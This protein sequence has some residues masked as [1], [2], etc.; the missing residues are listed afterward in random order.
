MTT[1]SRLARHTL[2]PLAMATPTIKPVYDVLGIF[3]TVTAV[4]YICAPFMLLNIYDSLRAWHTLGYYGFV[5]IFGGLAFFYSPVGRAA[6]ARAA[7]VTAKDKEKSGVQERR[8]T[9][10]LKA[11]MPKADALVNG[12]VSAPVTPS[13][14]AGV[15][16][17]F[18]SAAREWEN[19]R[20]LE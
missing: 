19:L 8:G 15:V 1:V 20:M 17:P 6:K 14:Y 5:T 9:E 10:G 18:D 7:A 4:N 11:E 3:A 2:R 16:P 12:N 13:A